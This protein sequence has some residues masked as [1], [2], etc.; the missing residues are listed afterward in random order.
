MSLIIKKIVENSLASYTNLEEGDRII[1]INGKNINDFLDLQYY[2]ADPILE[3]V[4]R[5]KFGRKK[6]IHIEQ[7]WQTPLGIE[8]EEHKIRT[9]ANHCIFCFVDQMRPD[10]RKTLFIK[11]D[12]YRFS[13][14]FGNFITLTNFSENDYK[15]IIEQKLSPLYISV[16][17]TNKELHRK[18]LRYNVKNFDILERLIFLSENN[19]QFHTQIVVVP[20][21]N[22]GKELTKTLDDLTSP[23]LN[24]LSIGI[25]PVGITRYRKNLHKIKR[26]D[27]NLANKLIEVSKNY[28]NTYCSDEIYLLAKKEIPKEEFYNDYPQLENGIGMIRLFLENWK[29]EKSDFLKFMN[30]IKKNIVFVTG[31]LFYD[32]MKRISYEINK[33][34]SF[35]SRVIKIRNDYLGESVTVAGLITASDIL[36]QLKLSHQELPA[37]SSNMFNTDDITL[38]NVSKFELKKKL[39]S[40]LLIIDEEFANWQII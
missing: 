17:T 12:D 3:I 38:D 35:K 6:Q 30:K 25:V 2:G 21:W 34:S 40:D 39:N 10:L 22:D 32:Y 24:T 31:A 1:T 9:C 27:F 4:V 33:L 20:G 18:M 19:I 15:K 37:L 36:K 26:V 5:D 11:D 7:D 29:Y 8:P 16:H 28:P 13:F 23:K 14:V